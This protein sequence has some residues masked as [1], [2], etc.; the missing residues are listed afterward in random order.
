MLSTLLKTFKE[1]MSGA[2]RADSFSGLNLNLAKSFARV[3]DIASPE[4]VI[5]FRE[6]GYQEH[7]MS[8]FA[9]ERTYADYL[10]IGCLA[11][12]ALFAL[13]FLWKKSSKTLIERGL[14][15]WAHPSE[16]K[17]ADIRSKFKLSMKKVMIHQRYEK[18]MKNESQEF[19]I[20]KKYS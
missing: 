5:F 15:K 18:L 12:T 4:I 10:I 20:K 14:K 16:R 11:A 7:G 8:D 9:A 13:N 3:P 6:K 19:G 17:C 2:Q 1:D